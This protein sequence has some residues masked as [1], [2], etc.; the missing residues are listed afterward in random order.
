MATFI[1]TFEYKEIFQ[2]P[3]LPFSLQSLQRHSIHTGRA[4]LKVAFDLHLDK[5]E[6]QFSVFIWL[7]I[8]IWSNWS[9]PSLKHYFIWFWDNTFFFSPCPTAH[10]FPDSSVGCFFCFRSWNAMMPKSLSLALFSIQILWVISHSLRGI[11]KNMYVLMT[12]SLISRPDLS[13]EF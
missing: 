5:A 2:I 3:H 8:G 4:F 10:T 1:K 7:L 13:S 12:K 9:F 11:K 6:G